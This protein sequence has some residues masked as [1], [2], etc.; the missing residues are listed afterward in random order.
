MATTIQSA[1]LC[2]LHVDSVFVEVDIHFGI[3]AFH[4]VGLPDRAVREA[5]GRI[6]SAFKQCKLDYPRYRILVNLA[7]AHLQKQGTHYDVPMALGLLVEQGILKQDACRNVLVIGELGLDGTIRPVHGALLLTQFAKASGMGQVIVPAMNAQE[8]ACI[9]GI[10]VVGVDHLSRL[11]AHMSG[12]EMIEP[13][14]PTRFAPPERT[15]TCDLS[16]VRGHAHAKRAL[17]IAAAGGHN[18][19]MSGPPG[20]GKTLLA[21]TLSTILPALS[22]QEALEVTSIHSVAGRLKQGY[23]S[24]RPFRAPHHTASGIALIGGGSKLQPGEIS[25]AHRGVLFLDEIAEFPSHVLEELRQPL[26][27]GTVTISR[28]AGTV[29]YPARFTLV[30]AMNPCPCGYANDRSNP[31]ICSPINIARYR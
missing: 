18:I 30:G 7:P 22:Q 28:V 24:Q 29:E 16:H 2:G 13:T 5:S 10:D 6:E 4:I 11:I 26:E 31:C 25:L 27:E 1:A 23:V 14:A 9:E 19:L 21:R 8:A 3:K 12:L 15:H 17:E 20:S